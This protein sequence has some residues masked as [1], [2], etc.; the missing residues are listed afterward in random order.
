M[1]IS[2][3]DPGLVQPEP[4]SG[5]GDIKLLADTVGAPSLVKV[6]MN[7]FCQVY[8]ISLFYFRPVPD[9]FTCTKKDVSY[10]AMRDRA[11]EVLGNLVRAHAPTIESDDLLL[12]LFAG[13]L[14]HCF[15]IYCNS[16]LI[17]LIIY[18]INTHCGVPR[19]HRSPSPGYV[20]VSDVD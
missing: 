2:C 13:A 11:L 5:R 17:Y 8:I 20:A 12:H 14:C 16:Q 10:P 1:D 4:H 15:C 19:P 9:P 6:K 18:A 7:E 3:L